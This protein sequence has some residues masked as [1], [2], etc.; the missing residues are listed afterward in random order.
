MPGIGRFFGWLDKYIVGY[1]LG[2]AA[3]P[4]LEPFVQHLANEGWVL[5]QVKP[6]DALVMAQI[7]VEMPEARGGAA[8]WAA[9]A[10]VDGDRF[11]QL[12]ELADAPPA[13]TTLLQLWRRNLISDAAFNVGL[14]HLKIETDYHDGLRGLREV[15]LSPQEAANAWQQGFMDETPASRE[16][17]LQ[18]VTPDRSQIQR[19]LAGL[20]PG[21][22][23]GLTLLR[24]NIINEDT[25]RQIVREGHT[26]VKYTE[27][28]LALRNQILTASQ[29]ATAWLK[30]HATEAEAKAG[31]ALQGYD[32]AAMELLYL[33]QGRPATTRQIH[34]GYARGANLPGAASERE[35]VETAVRQSNVRTEYTDLL[36]A[37]RESLPSAFVLRQLAT[38]GAIERDD[39]EKYLRWS[40]WPVEL[41]A[42]VA[43]AWAGTTATGP[44]T[45]WLDR[46]KSRLFTA[47]HD[48]YIDGN[49]DAAAAHTMLSR[50]G[51]GPAEADAI[52]ALWEVERTTTRR[53]L[54]QAQILKLYRRAL[55]TR[56]R[57]VAALEDMGMTPADAGDLLDTV[58][59]T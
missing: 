50:V 12:V 23:D 1:A 40:G 34:I 52:V 31:G 57:S 26:K 58:A 13:V 51:A 36:W 35:A 59:P 14:T 15:L 20:P 4:S 33:N 49:A 3:G 21:A 11:N 16:A 48:D 42:K 37:Q 5:N 54:T 8:A 56:E 29:W 6:L 47:A 28:L 46:A 38:S 19:E 32:A 44:S 18:G 27:A 24:R 30:G 45:K 41:A 9:M 17:E 43:D 55:W 22:M 39:A 2:T 25:Y 10:G 7:A 53:D